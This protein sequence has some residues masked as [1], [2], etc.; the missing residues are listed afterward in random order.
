MTFIIYRYS[1]F[2]SIT[3]EETMPI[4]NFHINF[5]LNKFTFLCLKCFAINSEMLSNINFNIIQTYSSVLIFVA[6]VLGSKT[7]FEQVLLSSADK[8]YLN[9]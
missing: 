5:W 3:S 9:S 8:V 6:I 1:D 2:Q 4:F 7:S